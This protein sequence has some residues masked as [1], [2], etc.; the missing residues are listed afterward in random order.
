MALNVLN[1]INLK[2]S[3]GLKQQADN[4][5]PANPT[6]LIGVHKVSLNNL[7]SGGALWLPLFKGTGHKP[8][9]PTPGPPGALPETWL[10]P[11][12][13]MKTCHA[14]ELQNGAT[15]K[16]TQPWTALYAHQLPRKQL[17]DLRA[18]PRKVQA[19][20]SRPYQVS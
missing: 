12:L 10:S 16:C 1:S 6:F 18:G 11:Q 20:P 17:P 8:C 2:T 9:I 7:Q 5:L 14:P 3:R 4:A 13:Q 19:V 15:P